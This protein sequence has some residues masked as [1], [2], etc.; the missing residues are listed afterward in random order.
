MTQQEESDRGLTTGPWWRFTRYEVSD[1]LI[2]PASGAKLERYDPWKEREE[3]RAAESY[4]PPYVKLARI[5]SRW[6]DRGI[7]VLGMPEFHRDIADWCAQFG[8]L[9]ILPQLVLSATPAGRWATVEVGK[10]DE[11]ATQTLAPLRPLSGSRLLPQV[12]TYERSAAGWRTI[13]T[14]ELPYA[15]ALERWPV[16]AAEGDILPARLVAEYLVPESDSLPRP[17][18]A[19]IRNVLAGYRL[20]GVRL[21]QIVPIEQLGRFFPAVPAEER[22]TFAYPAPESETFWSQYTEPLVDFYQAALVLTEPIQAMAE[23][24]QSPWQAVEEVARERL[25]DILFGISPRLPQ[26]ERHGVQWWSPSLMA[27]LAFMALDDIRYGARVAC[28][29][30]CHGFFIRRRPDNIYCGLGCAQTARKTRQRD[31]EAATAQK[32]VALGLSVEETAVRMNR[33]PTEI[34]R[35]LRRELPL[36]SKEAAANIEGRVRRLAKP[37]KR[38]SKGVAEQ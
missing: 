23:T 2:R 28:C 10:H 27:H 29:A 6:S 30:R 4:L 19:L 16:G 13:T 3:G 5:M 21:W 35:Y 9:G 31:V 26:G 33:T 15:A 18:T 11:R 24:A 17:G 32:L 7:A 14:C 12:T 34:R 20:S 22:A 38:S 1:G 8:L 37:D 36:F 25:H